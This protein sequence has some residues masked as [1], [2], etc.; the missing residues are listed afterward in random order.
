[1]RVKLTFMVEPRVVGTWSSSGVRIEV[2]SPSL[3]RIPEDASASTQLAGTITS[4]LVSRAFSKALV[5]AELY[6]VPQWYNVLGGLRDWARA[7]VFEQPSYMHKPAQARLRRSGSRYLPF[8]LNDLTERG[9]LQP[10]QR[11][12]RYIVSE[13]L[14]AYAMDT[15]GRDHLPRLVRGLRQYESWD[16]LIPAVYDM[17][18]DTF[19]AGWNQYLVEKYELVETQGWSAR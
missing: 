18:V 10:E 1:M 9:Q 11:L 5:T 4:H 17:D 2:T 15:Y 16:E 7:D 13:S 8:R 19:T 6:Y 14:A 12:M 3:Y